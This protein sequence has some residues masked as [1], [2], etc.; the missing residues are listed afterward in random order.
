MCALLRQQM[1]TEPSG[2][3]K[4]PQS[5]VKSEYPSLGQGRKG[6]LDFLAKKVSLFNKICSEN[7]Q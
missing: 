4:P 5:A 6:L 2:K 1:S 7:W 3:G